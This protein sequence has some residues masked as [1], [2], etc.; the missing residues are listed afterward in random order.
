MTPIIVGVVSG[1]QKPSMGYSRLASP[2]TIV[3]GD[4]I[5]NPHNLRST[6]DSPQHQGGEILAT[7]NLSI[8]EL[9]SLTKQH[10]KFIISV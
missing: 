7:F 8:V 10:S 6:P 3:M 5:S 9:Q 2:Q 1:S 4:T